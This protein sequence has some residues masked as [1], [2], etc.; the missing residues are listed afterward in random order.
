MHA[1]SDQNLIIA[2]PHRKRACPLT[3]GK[4]IIRYNLYPSILNECEAIFDRGRERENEQEKMP[5][6]YFKLVNILVRTSVK[7]I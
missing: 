4:A 3:M 6:L 2:F 5:D 1:C 7:I